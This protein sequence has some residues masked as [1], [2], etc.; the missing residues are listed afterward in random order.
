MAGEGLLRVTRAKFGKQREVPLHPSAASA[1]G[2]YARHRDELFPRPKAGAFLLGPSGSPLAYTTVVGTFRRLLEL[3]GVHAG[4]GQ[5]PPLI[6]SLRHT[7]TFA[8]DRVV[9]RRRRR[10]GTA[11]AA[12]DL[13]GPRQPEVDVL[14]PL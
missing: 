4:P 10:A 12:G 8:V 3:A 13:H 1:L 5:P 14:L 2:E 11:A 7:F 9:P 6:H